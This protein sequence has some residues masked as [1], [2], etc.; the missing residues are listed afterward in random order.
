[1]SM[2]EDGFEGHN[3]ITPPVLLTGAAVIHLSRA[4]EQGFCNISTG[5]TGLF[6]PDYPYFQKSRE[7]AENVN[8]NKDID[9]RR[10]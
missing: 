2:G 5:A 3:V 4:E 6:G 8:T 10:F 9:D 1:V 7:P